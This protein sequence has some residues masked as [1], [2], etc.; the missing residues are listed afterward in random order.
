MHLPF[1]KFRAG[2]IGTTIQVCP[3][4]RK[5]AERRRSSGSP[6]LWSSPLIAVVALSWTEMY[7]GMA[8]AKSKMTLTSPNDGRSREK[9]RFSASRPLSQGRSLLSC[10]RSLLRVCVGVLICGYN[11]QKWENYPIFVE[12]VV[13]QFN[14]EVWTCIFFKI[15]QMMCSKQKTFFHT[16]EHG[17]SHIEK[18]RFFALQM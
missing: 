16:V 3:C 1:G 4:Q 13:L 14:C 2:R 6:S 17:I 12:V 10:L 11:W 18:Q 8:A 9:R 5:P 7:I 15:R